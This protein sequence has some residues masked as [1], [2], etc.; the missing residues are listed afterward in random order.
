MGQKQ[1]EENNNNI[2]FIPTILC[3]N[4][5]SSIPYFYIFIENL[6]TKIKINCKCKNQNIL[7][8]QEYSNQLNNISLNRIN[9][10]NHINQNAIFFCINCEKWLCDKCY[11]EHNENICIKNQTNDNSLISKCKLHI[12]NDNSFYCKQCKIFL[13]KEC[14]ICHNVKYIKEHEIIK[15]TDYLTNKKVGQSITNF[16][17]YKTETDVYNK[18]QI[19]LALEQLKNTKGENSE[20][21]INLNQLYQTHIGINEQLLILV[22]LLIDTIKQY[23]VKIKNKKFIINIINNIKINFSEIK[24]DKS[25]NET[26]IN[27]IK[28]FLKTN[29]MIIKLTATFNNIKKIQSSNSVNFLYLLPN[30]KFAAIYNDSSIKI[31]NGNSNEIEF[32]LIGHTNIITN[33]ILLNDKETL[34]SISNDLNIIL[35]NIINGKQIKSI[36]ISST[37]RFVFQNYNENNQLIILSFGNVIDIWDINSSNKISSLILKEYDWFESCYQLKN[38]QNYLLG[39]KGGFLI[40]NNNFEFLKEIKIY[41][42][43]P[44]YFLELSNNNILVSMR[45]NHIFIYDRDYNFKRRFI[46]HLKDIT[47]V[48]EYD[49]NILISCSSDATFKLWNLNNSELNQV[50][51]VNIYPINSIIKLENGNIVFSSKNPEFP[52]EI[53]NIINYNK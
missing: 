41:Q 3:P 21:Y 15:W 40:Y 14:S 27:D 39:K 28:S 42:Q 20:D 48:I 47:G 51:E 44:F 30:N 46:A 1:I 38:N 5:F 35:W 37:P 29:F 33:V 25:F 12:K 22:D 11:S 7:L 32:N 4:C 49:N 10:I 36:F 45:E 16:N 50:F 43:I 8:L 17:L 24:V 34:V 18:I 53:W 6:T 52:I 19:E 9:C 26:A 2:K 23:Q 13:C 31:Y